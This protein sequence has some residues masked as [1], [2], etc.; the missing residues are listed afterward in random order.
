MKKASLLETERP[1]GTESNR[2]SQDHPKPA[3]RKHVRE[4]SK[5][6]QGCTST[7]NGPQMHV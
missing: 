5:D 6:Q 1:H 7:L 4:P 3:T 2:L